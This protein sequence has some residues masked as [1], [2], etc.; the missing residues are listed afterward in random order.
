MANLGCVS[1]RVVAFAKKEI[2]V[3]KI[4]VLKE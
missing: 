4:H 3:N 1:F 2:K